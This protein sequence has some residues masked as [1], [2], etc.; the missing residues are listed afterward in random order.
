MAESSNSSFFALVEY[1]DTYV[2]PLIE[3]AFHKLL[4]SASYV[5]IKSISE[6][7][8]KNPALLQFRAYE[9]LD[10]EQ[11]LEN[12]NCLIN[13]YIIRKAL[14]RKHHLSNTILSWTTKHLDSVLKDHFQACNDFEVDY[15]EFLDDSL[16]E[17]YELRESWQRGDGLESKDREWWILKPS[18]ADRGQG[19]RLFSDETELTAIFEEWDPEDSDEEDEDDEAKATKPSDNL[20]DEKDQIITAHLRH[21]VAQPY[22]HPPLLL[23]SSADRKFHIRTYVLAVGALKVYVYKPML[24]L[25]AEESYAPPWEQNNLRAHLTNTCIQEVRDR[26]GTVREF[27]DLD[28]TVPSLPATSWKEDVFSQICAVT[29][30][31]F[32]AAARNNSVHFQL[33]PNAFELFGLDYLVDEQG[34]AYLLEVN[35]FPDFRQTGK[36]LKGLVGGLFE[37]VVEVAIMPFFG[38]EGGKA[39]GSKRMV[40]VLDIDMGRR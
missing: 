24:A 31:V 38:L 14:I 9:S 17:C 19:I 12:P 30:E 29:G 22:I 34:K 13:A 18:M 33:L 23:S 36:D 16:I 6:C 21:L 15:A 5:S 26:E 32:Q 20:S 10:L 1:E 35:A 25:F 39:G 7:S 3:E 11:A 2:Q 40:M 8:E 27:W 28:E 4:P 37:E